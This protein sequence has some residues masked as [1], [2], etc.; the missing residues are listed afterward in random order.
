MENMP[1]IPESFFSRARAKNPDMEAKLKEWITSEWEKCISSPSY[2]YHNYFLVDGKKPART[3]SDEQ[4]DGLV[5]QWRSGKTIT[6]FR[7]RGGRVRFM[8][9]K[10]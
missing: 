2:F 8:A 6:S 5:K 7:G 1:L 9:I 3:M 10:D 4:F